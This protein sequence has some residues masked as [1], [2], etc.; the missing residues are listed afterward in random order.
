[1]IKKRNKIVDIALSLSLID[2]NL[3]QVNKT[4]KRECVYLNGY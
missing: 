1:M 4:S 3:L 2:I